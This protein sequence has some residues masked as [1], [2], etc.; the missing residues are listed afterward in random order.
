MQ[1]CTLPVAVSP[2][3]PG[4]LPVLEW[5]AQDWGYQGALTVSEESL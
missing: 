4:T 5:F 2:V 3:L 1:W